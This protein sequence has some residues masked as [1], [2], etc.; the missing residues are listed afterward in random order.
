[1]V[2]FKLIDKLKEEIEKYI[3]IPY[4]KNVLKEGKIFQEKVLGGKGNWRQ[5]REETLKAAKNQNI[6]LEKLTA[7]ELYNFQKKNHIGIDCSGLVYHLLDVYDLL[8]GREGILNKT[9]GAGSQNGVRRLS[10]DLLTSTINSFHIDN[11]NE[12][13][14]GDMI[15]MDRGNHILFVVE[16]S[17]NIIRYVHSSDRTLTRGVHYGTI[18][19][20]DPTK[21]L[22]FQKWSDSTLNGQNYSEL[23]YPESGD[24][25]YRLKCF[26]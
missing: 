13:Q 14:T 12:I 22:K 1:M 3:G 19:I 16:P 8:N 20:I 4:S 21:S 15:R 24:G 17:E 23:F 25:I 5:I 11:Y 2:G 6:D 9:I 10:A 18:E 26:C 7:K